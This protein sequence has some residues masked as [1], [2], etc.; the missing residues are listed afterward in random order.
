M[1][2]CGFELHLSGSLPVT[3]GG[4]STE[5]QTH[6]AT[7][8]VHAPAR[9]D[10]SVAEL[11]LVLQDLAARL[12]RPRRHRISILNFRRQLFRVG[13]D[14]ADSWGSQNSGPALTGFFGPSHVVSR[15]DRLKLVLALGH[16]RWGIESQS[17]SQSLR[18][19][20]G[21]GPSRTTASWRAVWRVGWRAANG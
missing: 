15:L 11:H 4:W 18:W 10:A 16:R 12:H 21:A 1:Q 9:R 6:R 7:F 5:F 2:D 20:I 8:T 3:P 19:A 14:L 13:G 17:K